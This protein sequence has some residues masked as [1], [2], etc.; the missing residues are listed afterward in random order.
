M[1]A[2][3]LAVVLVLAGFPLALAEHVAPSFLETW[4]TGTATWTRAGPSEEMVDDCT[5]G[6]PGCSLRVT[7]PC[8]SAHASLAASM[9]IPIPVGRPLVIDLDFM[10]SQLTGDTDVSIRLDFDQGFAVLSPSGGINNE[11]ELRTTDDRVL[12]FAVYSTA[13]RWNHVDVS[14]NGSAVSAVV[15]DGHG[16]FVAQSGNVDVHATPTRLLKITLVA[17]TWKEG[18]KTTFWLDDIRVR[19][20]HEC[21]LLTGTLAATPTTGEYPL[22]VTLSPRVTRASSTCPL[23]WTLDF[24]DGETVSGSGTPPP[25]F[26][27]TY[28]SNATFRPTFT[29]H[30]DGD[31]RT[32]GATVLARSCM[33]LIATLAPP[34]TEGAAP[35]EAFPVA[36]YGSSLDRCAAAWSFDPGDGS[37]PLTG[38]GAPP[39][40]LAYAYAKPGVH[41]ARFEATR[42][43]ETRT[44]SRIFAAGPYE[45]RTRG[46][47][48]AGANVESTS[49]WPF[50][51]AIVPLG[52]P[53]D[54]SDVITLTWSSPAPADLDLWFRVG[55]RRTGQPC[56]LSSTNPPETCLVPRGAD[57]Y[58]VEPRYGALVAWEAVVTYA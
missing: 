48:D 39:A 29:L 14:V 53:T 1:R 37:A 2:P 31:S 42:D 32:S 22:A 17:V 45:E 34:A 11:V 25:S 40:G 21:G 49:L 18:G 51:G 28:I 3:I 55:E 33:P 13:N 9:D 36:S 4:E 20:T 52:E 19:E 46:T 24:G 30:Q 8:C 26:G 23:A 43:G 7:A 6:D 35:F 12:P 27:H 5:R 58:A 50:F 47:I 56:E 16:Q 10:N 38:R 44:A 54:G 57:S 15:Y 41:V